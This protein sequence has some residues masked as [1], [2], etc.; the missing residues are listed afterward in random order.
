MNRR[1]HFLAVKICEYLEIPADRVY[2]NWACLKVCRVH[3]VDKIRL[4]NEDEDTI[5]RAIVEKLHRQTGAR[6]D[7]AAKTAFD[8]GRVGLAT[9]VLP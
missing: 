6:F 2:T 9:K 5:C 8:E 4:S 1:E 3:Y 7:E